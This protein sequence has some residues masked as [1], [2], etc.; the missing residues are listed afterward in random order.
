[1]VELLL[2]LA[3]IEPGA[4]PSVEAPAETEPAVNVTLAE[5]A[6]AEPFRVPVTLAGPALVDEVSVAV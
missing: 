2:P 3:V 6:I 4:A 5:L 1:M